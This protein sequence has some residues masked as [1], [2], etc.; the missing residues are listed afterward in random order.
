MAAQTRLTGAAASAVLPVEDYA[1]A[2]AFYQDKVGFEVQDA[3]EQ[4]G[5]GFILTGGGTRVLLYQ[6]ERTKAE[7]TVLGFE[8]DDIES[9]VSDLRAHGVRFEDYD[10]PNLHTDD[11]IAWMGE[12]ASAWFTDPEGN[13]I[14]INQM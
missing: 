4:E 12:T 7:H 14:S 9:V 2:K 8:V 6:R 11:G 3:P 1:R 5:M 10:M 13:I